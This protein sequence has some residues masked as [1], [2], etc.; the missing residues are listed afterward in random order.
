[1]FT[2][3]KFLLGIYL[4]RASVGSAY[5]AAGSL[6]AVIVWVYYSAQI[7]FFGAAFTRVYS[8]MHVR[9]N[10]PVVSGTSAAS[11]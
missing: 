1:M 7:F 6:V 8:D 2:I 3:G 11:A 10:E 5:G 9:Q 4:G